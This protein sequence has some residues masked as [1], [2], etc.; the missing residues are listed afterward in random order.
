MMQEVRKT[1]VFQEKYGDFIVAGGG[2]EPRIIV[3]AIEISLRLQAFCLR[4]LC[5]KTLYFDGRK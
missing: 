3:A 5:L 1:T 2:F 4:F